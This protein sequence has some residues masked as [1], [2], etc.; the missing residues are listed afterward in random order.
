MV[1]NKYFDWSFPTPRFAFVIG[2]M[3]PGV[4]RSLNEEQ[5]KRLIKREHKFYLSAPGRFMWPND[6]LV[7]WSLCFL[8]VPLEHVVKPRA[9]VLRKSRYPAM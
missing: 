4:L 2:E 9:L 1:R 5:G 6:D 7:V 3:D 8:N